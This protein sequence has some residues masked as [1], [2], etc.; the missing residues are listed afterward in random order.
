MTRLIYA[1]AL[2]W[3]IAG[4][5]CAA[6]PLTYFTPVP[7]D[8]EAVWEAGAL[9]VDK[10]AE[11]G[12]AQA[13]GL[14]VGD[15]L[16]GCAG[17]R[18]R[19]DGELR[20]CLG[21]V[22]V[23]SS[24]TVAVVRAGHLQRLTIA[25]L[26]E[27]RLGAVLVN[28][29]PP[30][31]GVAMTVLGI[32]PGEYL[33]TKQGGRPDGGALDALLATYT[34]TNNHQL[35]PVLNQ[36]AAFPARGT[37]AIHRLGPPARAGA[38]DW[39]LGLLKTH[40]ALLESRTADARRHLEEGRLLDVHLDPFLDGLAGFYAKL[41]ASRPGAQGADLAGYSVTPEY[42]A[43]CFPPPVLPIKRHDWTPLSPAFAADF[44]R[45][46]SGAPWDPAERDR[47]AR[48]YEAPYDA[49]AAER[50]VR[51]LYSAL[52]DQQQHGGWP[53]RFEPMMDSADR[54]DLLAVL[55]RNFATNV[56]ERVL[57]ALALVAPSAV[58]GDLETYRAAM[59]A[60]RD[61]GSRELAEGNVITRSIWNYHW[62]PARASVY[63]IHREINEALGIDPFYRWLAEQDPT[64]A[65][66][67]AWG[68]YILN[69]GGLR[70]GTGLVRSLATVNALG[71][72]VE[73]S[74]GP[75]VG[76]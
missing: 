61:A 60:L 29:V 68:W 47:A 14:C 37:E 22:P 39:V 59:T 43:L 20:M 45:A 30:V 70:D 74:A 13:A 71:G 49:P 24:V 16:V 2:A 11:G 41:A 64:H 40:Y 35:H 73:L 18:V 23:G 72:P 8:P 67:F 51:Y 58:E 50:Y 65:E 75:A 26:D 34:P 76:Q 46:C 3:A 62:S 55:K 52:V 31:D 25:E 33:G 19:N 21:L 63:G 66:R 7:S 56:R 42:F 44:E 12:P 9:R 5:L 28:L 6:P 38:R 69:G 32:H 36:L 48:Q 53:I 10:L 15:R 17:V 54:A 27:G 4:E 57:C 1:W